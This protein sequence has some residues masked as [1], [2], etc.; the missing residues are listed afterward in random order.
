ML[1]MSV[2]EILGTCVI[3]GDSVPPRPPDNENLELM[4]GCKLTPAELLQW[5]RQEKARLGRELAKDARLWACPEHRRLWDETL[6]LEKLT[7][8]HCYGVWGA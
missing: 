6:E 8:W 1:R 5:T 3:L 2:F 7:L 4:A